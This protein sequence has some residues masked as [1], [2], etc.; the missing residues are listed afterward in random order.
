MAE[1]Y[2]ERSDSLAE[3]LVNKAAHDETFTISNKAPELITA[4]P[5]IKSSAN[6]V[7]QSVNQPVAEKENQEAQKLIVMRIQ[8]PL[9]IVGNQ[10]QSSTTQTPQNN[11]TA[12]DA[13]TQFLN[14]SS[15]GEVST[16]QAIVLK[17]P[18]TLIAQGNFIYATLDTAI[19][20]DL[21]G[22]IRAT[23]TSPI[24]A[25]DGAQIL[26]HAGSRLIGQYKSGLSLGQ[27]RVFVVWTRL[28]DTHGYSISLS[29]PGT[30]SL[31]VTGMT[32]EVDHHF[33]QT[34]GNAALLSLLGAGASNIGVH[35]Q[36]QYNSAA[37]YRQAISQSL[38]QSAS[39]SLQQGATPPTININQGEKINV[40]VAKDLRFDNAKN[41]I[42]LSVNVF[43]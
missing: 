6:I 11:S 15:S 25:E 7:D 36:D 18:A 27:S 20:S 3:T 17:K 38:S 24:Y 30:D 16:S 21:P 14:E 35:T 40:F 28:I 43:N 8:A 12:S 37:A 1:K 9:M 26:I 33:W 22:Q 32:G 31:G 4:P 19:N 13:N 41:N 5:P 23:V 10:S 2:H 42:G 39:N 29:S 34:F